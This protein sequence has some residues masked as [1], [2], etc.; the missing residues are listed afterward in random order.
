MRRL[1]E[2]QV[3]RVAKPAI[4]VA[5]GVLIRHELDPESPAVGVERL[6][7]LAGERRRVLPDL[8]VAAVGEGVLD[9][10]LE[11]VQLPL[12]EEI[13]ELVQGGHRRDPIPAHIEHDAAMEE[14]GPILDLEAGKCGRARAGDL[15]QGHRRI[16]GPR[17]VL[18]LDLD[19]IGEDPQP[20][21]LRMPDGAALDAHDGLEAAR[22]RDMLA[23]KPFDPPWLGQKLE[24]RHRIDRFDHQTSRLRRRAESARCFSP[25]RG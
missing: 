22:P 2:R 21:P 5:E 18:G 12:G 13:D 24:R 1:G 17:L 6:D 19:A 3:P 20:I 8:V 15:P 4:H 25:R 7:L 11:L 16:P 23:R 9:V 10:E 14:V